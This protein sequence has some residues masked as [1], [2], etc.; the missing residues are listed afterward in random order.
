MAKSLS[1][2]DVKVA[3]TGA[4]VGPDSICA[5]TYYGRFDDQL[6]GWDFHSGC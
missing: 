6:D 4:P 1:A 2:S 3:H 5:D